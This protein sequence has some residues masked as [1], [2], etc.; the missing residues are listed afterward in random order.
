MTL[1]TT[2]TWTCS[3][4]LCWEILRKLA[5]EKVAMEIPAQNLRVETKRPMQLTAIP[6]AAAHQ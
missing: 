6:S 4:R 3:K 2:P 5:T 1:T